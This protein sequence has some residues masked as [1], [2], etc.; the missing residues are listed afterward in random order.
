[1]S[2][3]SFHNPNPN[4]PNALNGLEPELS[5]QLK[6]KV[7]AMRNAFRRLFI[8]RILEIL[9]LTIKWL[10]SE[11]TA[12]DVVRC[13]LALR[14]NNKLAIGIANNGKLM[15]LGIV[16]TVQGVSDA[17]NLWNRRRLTERDINWIIP[18]PLRPKKMREITTLDDCET[19][20]FVVLTNKVANYVSDM[21]VIEH[22]AD[23]LAE[24]ITS[25]YSLAIQAKVMTFFVSDTN[26]E[27]AN[28][29][30]SDIYNGGVAT[31]VD[32]Y[33]DPK[34]QIITVDN[35]SLS[36]NLVELKREYQNILSECLNMLGLNSLAVDKE[37]GVSDTEANS[38]RAFTT[39]NGNIYLE[40]RN[41]PFRWLEKRFGVQLRAIY[42]DGLDSELLILNTKEEFDNNENH[43]DN[44]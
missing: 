16:T 36:S 7:V 19:G 38:N 4:N 26:D 33:F 42:N 40:A 28:Q 13:E 35:A 15:L 22:Y 11:N 8:N 18:R 27:T 5:V 23:R 39:G 6:A 44:V 43:N 41:R 3:H 9:P 12:L 31:K 32:G 1:M 10:G 24:L 2:E 29:L 34:E 30:I 37:S 20:N 14:Q 25:R 21:E 17:T